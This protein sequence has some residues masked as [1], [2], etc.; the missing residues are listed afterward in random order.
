MSSTTFEA[1]CAALPYII[2][3]AIAAM[4]IAIAVGYHD[5]AKAAKFDSE[6]KP[7]KSDGVIDAIFEA[8]PT[9]N[10]D[11][12]N[13][14]TIKLM[15]ELGELSEAY[16]NVT[17][18]SNG[19]GLSY[20]DVREEAVDCLI[21]AADLALTSTPDQA[22]LSSEQVTAAMVEMIN[23]KLA[24]WKKNRDTGKSATDAE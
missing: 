11:N 8:N 14:R 9:R 19:K 3:V 20:A 13:R 16:L 10:F 24:K 1:F 23:L 2:I 18:S 6:V 12:Y 4:G 5:G 15:E 17:S 7:L 21:V 22:G